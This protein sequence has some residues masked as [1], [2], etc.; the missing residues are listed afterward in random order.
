MTQRPTQHPNRR[1]RHQATAARPTF[2]AGLVSGDDAR[3][4]I[5]RLDLDYDTAQIVLAVRRLI[6]T[7][8]AA[9]RDRKSNATRRTRG[10]PKPPAALR[11]AFVTVVRREVGA[12]HAA[13]KSAWP[14]IRKARPPARAAVI[15]AVIRR[16]LQIDEG[17]PIKAEVLDFT[18]GPR[19]IAVLV[20]ARQRGL[21]ASAVEKLARE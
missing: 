17:D 19:R 6:A 11:A 2:A 7:A 15:A 14:E 3:A 16:A 1:P 13:L 10:R 21:T 8:R 4:V 12:L 18:L 9:E 20:I 5:L